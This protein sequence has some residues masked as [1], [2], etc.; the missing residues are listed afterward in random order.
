[1]ERRSNLMVLLGIAFLLVGGAIVFVVL[2]DDDDGDAASSTETPVL[3]AKADIAPGTLGDDVIEQGLVE[4]R[5]LPV[6]AVP[7]GA[8]ASEVQLA[9]TTVTLAVPAESPILASNVVSNLQS[10]EVP[11]GFE[12]V[13]IQTDFTAGAAQ[14]VRAGDEINIYGVFPRCDPDAGVSASTQG[15]DPEAVASECLG[16][17]TPRVELL[18]TKVL[19]LDADQQ[20]APTAPA[21]ANNSGTVSRPSTGAPITF[22]LAVDTADAE[23][24]IQQIRFAEV[25]VTLPNEANPPAG[26]TPGADFSVIL[27]EEPNVAFDRSNPDD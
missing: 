10:I 1:M 5:N 14:F 22:F 25:Y 21:G 7:Q 16:P 9:G 2:Q 3:V 13:A 8:L 4:V 12:G 24:L 15:G 6:A 27:G 26:P 23:K 11:E 17:N 20:S 18:L 19:V